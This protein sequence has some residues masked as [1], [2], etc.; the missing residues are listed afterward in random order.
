MKKY[1]ITGLVILL[2]VALT[3]MIILFLFDFFTGPFVPLVSILLSQ[4]ELRFDFTLPVGLALFISRL[5][6]LIFLC[7]FILFLGALARWFLTKNLLSWANKIFSRIPIIKTIYNVSRDVFSALFSS[8]GKKAFKYPVLLPFPRRP[9]FSLG[10]RAGDVAQ[11]IQTKVKEPLT[12]VFMPT[13]PHPISG[14]LFLCPEKDVYKVEMTNEEAV[15]FLV[16]CGMIHPNAE[17]VE[18]DESL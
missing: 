12:A 11:E 16:S 6:A 5:F 15:K 18:L 3:V 4:F 9:A 1:F 17:K 2:P 7:F 10:F 8:D 13:A 14:F